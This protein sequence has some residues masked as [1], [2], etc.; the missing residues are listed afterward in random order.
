[1]DIPISNILNLMRQQGVQAA[2]GMMKPTG[3]SNQSIYWDVSNNN[4]F[5]IEYI[6]ELKEV[7]IYY[8]PQ[9]ITIPTQNQIK[10][11]ESISTFDFLNDEKSCNFINNILPKN[12][13]IYMDLL[14]AAIFLAINNK[15]KVIAFK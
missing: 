15:G 14:Q 5:I 1:M 7:T 8:I 9:T 4:R 11:F 12:N 10:H 6:P 13:K 2:T 3:Q